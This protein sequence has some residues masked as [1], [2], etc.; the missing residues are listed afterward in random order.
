MEESFVG[1][2]SFIRKGFILRGIPEAC[3][4]VMLS[5]ISSSTL[6]QYESELKKWWRYC[7]QHN[8]YVYTKSIPTILNFL[9]EEFRNGASFGTLNSIR[10][11]ISLAVAPKLGENNQVKRF[12]KGI[13]N[14][15]P[16]APRYLTT[17]DPAKVLD[18]LASWFP[19]EELCLRKLSQKLIALLAL[20]T[21]HRMQTFSVIN[22]RDIYKKDDH[23][24]IKIPAK[25]KTSG[26]NRLQPV[27]MLPF[28]AD[29]P[30]LCAANTLLCY[31]QRT[32]SLRS[33][34]MQQLFL[35]YKKPYKPATK[36]TLSRWL[37]TILQESGIDTKQFK[38]HSSRHA[39]TSTAYRNGISID[40][41][42]TT[43]G[44]TNRSQVFAEFYNRPIADTGEFARA[45]VNQ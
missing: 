44:W 38:P 32:E 30:E 31:L 2:R 22:I 36:A 4:E 3:L 29:K 14:L 13:Y 21:A 45:I 23:V 25:I 33:S 12:F 9:E 26:R 37:K 41:I 7:A 11:A 19:N 39:S 20:V 35:T 17:W 15:R 18:Y 34:N 43:A 6:K 1:G 16:S 8:I 28:F 10:A 42:R 40:V 24:E 5:S 27:L